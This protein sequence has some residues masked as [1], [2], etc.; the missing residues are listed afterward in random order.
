MTAS[1]AVPLRHPSPPP[2]LATLHKAP[3]RTSVKMDLALAII[4]LIKTAQYL[5]KSH[6][7]L[8]TKIS[9]SLFFCV[10]LP[11]LLIR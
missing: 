10:S 5:I 7:I 1:I 2:S 3:D 4:F 6:C 8:I 9:L 11:L